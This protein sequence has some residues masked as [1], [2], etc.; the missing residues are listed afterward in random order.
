MIKLKTIMPVAAVCLSLLVIGCGRTEE[1]AHEGA[2]AEEAHGHPHEA[3]ALEPVSYTIYTDKT[4]LF[5]E[6]KPLVVGETSSFAAHLTRLGNKFTPLTEGQLTVSLVK[7]NQG[8]RNTVEKPRSPGI[9]GPSLQPKTAGQGYTLIFDVKA[10]DLTDRIEIPNVQV[11]ADTKA[12]LTA[13]AESEAAPAGEEIPFLKEQAWKTDFATQ[14]VT[15]QPFQHIIKASGQIM[16]AQGDEKIVTANAS[17]VVSL[18]GTQIVAG[19]PVSARSKLFT[20]SG[21]GIAEGNVD[22]RYQETRTNYLRA[23]ADYARAKELVADKIISQREFEQRKANYDN[24][25]VAYRAI[26]RNYGPNGQSIT[27]PISGFITAIQVSDGQ[28]VEAGQPLATVSQNERLILRAEVSQTAAAKLANVTSASFKVPGG[29]VYDTQNLNGKLLAYGKSAGANSFMLPIT[30]EIANK[31]GITPGAF[32]E[33]YLRS[34]PIPNALVVP[35][36]AIME[37]Q[38]THYV[39]VQTKG[40]TFERREVAMGPSDGL[41]VQL[42]SGV[43]A[44]ERVVTVGAYQ[45]KLSSASGEVPAHGH[46]H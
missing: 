14:Q 4:E 24:A 15:P 28:H 6:F 10:G 11:Y 16:P 37:E 45:I 29:D 21:G 34:A 7:G 2:A 12:A 38:G 43:K 42:L 39:Y 26:S 3:S 19:A 8:I 1:H 40:E 5:V 36:S 46:E 20:I 32:V 27:A 30:F 41:R 33:V 9:F 25:A 18:A 31:E 13:A 22:T 23:Q 35:V 17:G 44:G